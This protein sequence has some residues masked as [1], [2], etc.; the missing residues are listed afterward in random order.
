MK[1][2]IFIIL[3]CVLLLLVLINK[4]KNKKEHFDSWTSSS[5]Q[6]LPCPLEECEINSKYGGCIKKGWNGSW[7][8]EDEWPHS[9]DENGPCGTY[10]DYW[11]EKKLPCYRK[12]WKECSWNDDG[13]IY[14]HHY[15]KCVGY[16]IDGYEIPCGADE[17]VPINGDWNYY[18]KS[19]PPPPNTQ[20]VSAPVYPPDG[21]NNEQDFVQADCPDGCMKIQY[22][23][24]QT[25]PTCYDNSSFETGNFNIC[26]IDDD[27]GFEPGSGNGGGKEKPFFTTSS[28]VK[29]AKVILEP[30]PLPNPTFTPEPTTNAPTTTS[31]TTNA[32]TT[33]STTTVPQCSFLP[34]GPDKEA[35]INR[36]R[37]PED[38]HLWG[39]DHCSLNKC[40]EICNNCNTKRCMWVPNYI[41]TD[42]RCNS[43]TNKNACN[44]QDGCRYDAFELKCKSI[45]KKSDRITPDHPPKQLISVV[46]VNNSLTV[47][48]KSKD[49]DLANTGFLIRYF[50]TFKPFEGLK[51]KYVEKNETDKYTIELEDL[52]N[53][54]YSVSVSAINEK[55]IGDSSNI[56][57]ISPQK[58]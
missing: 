31:I 23:G 15:G 35:C 40:E 38:R 5:T 56:V 8:N 53:E 28:M 54:E 17:S 44:F 49:K 13:R 57:R 6:P 27:M 9:C 21:N 39:G 47:V 25:S 52:D 50:K 58:M 45:P 30:E 11:Y 20:M 43:F 14:D 19:T 22:S 36:C 46:P 42:D 18:C 1:L 24:G 7:D 41:Y 48:W 37:N 55:G 16:N 3:L 51:L 33:T 29:P 34:W 4:N 10:Y 2:S 26:T 12:E 32:P